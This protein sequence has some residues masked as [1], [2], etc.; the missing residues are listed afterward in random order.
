M[1]RAHFVPPQTFARS[2]LAVAV[3]S[4]IS[5]TALAQQGPLEEI[6]VTARKRDENLQDVPQAIQAISGEQIARA[7]IQGIDD[8]SRL[9]PSMS[10]VTYGPGTSKIVFRGVADSAVSF[11]ADASAAVYLDEQALTQNS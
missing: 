10:Y 2:L 1:T 8:Y 9:I 4:A 7:G 6:I 11:I 3:S 5:G